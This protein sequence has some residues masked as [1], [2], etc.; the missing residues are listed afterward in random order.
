MEAYVHQRG[1][2]EVV[3]GAGSSDLREVQ[4]GGCRREWWLVSG[5]LEARVVAGHGLLHVAGEV[6]PQV[7]AISHLDGVRAPCRTPSA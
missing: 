1:G 3:G 6:V 4:V 5:L 2:L 7:P